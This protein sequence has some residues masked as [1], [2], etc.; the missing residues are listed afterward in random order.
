MKKN[1]RKKEC[2]FSISDK[3]SDMKNSVMLSS[4]NKKELET[5]QTKVHDWLGR[6]LG[7]HPDIDFDY[8]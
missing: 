4:W 7:L 8:A 1:L 2:L 6:I 5:L 3:R